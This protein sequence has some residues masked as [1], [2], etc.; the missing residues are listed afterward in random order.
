M[1][2][3]M[4]P[5]VSEIRAPEPCHRAART[6]SRIPGP[7]AMTSAPRQDQR[8]AE[9][10]E[11]FVQHRTVQRDRTPEVA[12]CDVRQP[13]EVLGHERPVQAKVLVQPGDLLGGCQR[14][15]EDGGRVAGRQVHDDERQH[16]DAQQHH[17]DPEE[18]L[19]D[20]A[21]HITGRP[22]PWRS[23]P[24]RAYSK[25]WIVGV[26]PTGGAIWVVGVPFGMSLTIASLLTAELA[27]RRTR[28]SLKGLL[29]MMRA[30]APGRPRVR[31]LTAYRR[32]LA[33]FETG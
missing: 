15:K 13:E 33:P 30:P 26:I 7:T 19:R 22:R 14:A 9:T 24:I 28:T 32:L 21:T 29:R 23:W 17:N 20:V 4:I 6:P 8:G 5:T 2:T 18:S 25:V 1:P 31:A 12:A 3:E 16:C 11:H 27:A 10:Q